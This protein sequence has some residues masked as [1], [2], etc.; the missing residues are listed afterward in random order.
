MSRG[1]KPPA[2]PDLPALPERPACC[3]IRRTS[4]GSS[5][6]RPTAGCSA[7]AYR[8]F[9]APL[10]LEAAG[11][12]RDW[13]TLR[14]DLPPATPGAFVLPAVTS[15]ATWNPRAWRL[16]KS[17]PVVCLHYGQL[18][19]S[20]SQAEALN[21]SASFGGTDV[22]H[23]TGTTGYGSPMHRGYFSRG[24]DHNVPLVNGEGEDLGPLE[25]RREWVVERG[26]PQSP[27]RGQLL[28]FSPA[29]V[30]AAQP[31]YRGDV[32]ARRTLAIEGD[33]LVGDSRD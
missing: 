23:D 2:Q 24:A 18:T 16:V 30:S 14:L 1:G 7:R 33:R 8:V 13:D 25:E 17:G 19:R 29:K 15:R 32:Q 5:R 3:R 26:D 10:G 31:H 20:H 28:E 4:S 22:T 9:P 6:R 27:L 21:F 11:G 12:R